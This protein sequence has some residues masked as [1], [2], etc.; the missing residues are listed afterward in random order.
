MHRLTSALWREIPPALLLNN[1]SCAF[2]KRPCYGVE[3]GDTASNTYP[4][5]KES[6]SNIDRWRS[7]CKTGNATYLA[8]SSAWS[9]SDTR[10]A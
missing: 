2:W 5:R 9:I 1:C 8:G 3:R 4:W 7:T 6:S 10:G